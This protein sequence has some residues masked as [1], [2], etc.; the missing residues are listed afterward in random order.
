MIKSL[1]RSE[2]I[3]RIDLCELVRTELCLILHGPN[4]ST[5]FFFFPSSPYIAAPPLS[6]IYLSTTNVEHLGSI[7][8]PNILKLISARREFT[9][10]CSFLARHHVNGHWFKF[11]GMLCSSTCVIAW[12]MGMS[13][14]MSKVRYFWTSS[15]SCVHWCHRWFLR[16]DDQLAHA[17]VPVTWRWPPHLQ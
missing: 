13:A 4:W 8:F 14:S 11:I 5:C 10:C 15:V 2:L 9:S 7:T 3:V 6:H 12:S 17:L 16:E 1:C